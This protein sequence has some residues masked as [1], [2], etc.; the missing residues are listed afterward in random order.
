[1]WVASP[2]LRRRVADGFPETLHDTPVLLPDRASS[3]RRDL[4]RWFEQRAIRPRVVAEVGDSAL[5][6]ALGA[7]GTG[8]VPVPAWV[9][10]RVTRQYDMAPV[11]V[12]SGVQV[13]AYGLTLPGRGNT[14][15]L[16]AVLDSAS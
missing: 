4:E 13:A 14:A 12:A 11:G 10:D 6:K 16:R 3:L 2:A 7:E 1:M 8:L 9:T 15:V 5:L